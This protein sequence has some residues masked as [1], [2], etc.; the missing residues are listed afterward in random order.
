FHLGARYQANDNVTFNFR[1]NNLLDDDLS[2]I[3]YTLNEQQDGYN[4]LHDYDTPEKARSF[5]L[6]TNVTF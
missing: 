5:W 4:R 1:V 2:S 6:S 3:T